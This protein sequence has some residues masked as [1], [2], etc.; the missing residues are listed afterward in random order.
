ML[1]NFCQIIRRSQTNEQNCTLGDP[2]SSNNCMARKVECKGRDVKSM[3]NDDEPSAME[4]DVEHEVVP[5]TSIPSDRLDSLNVTTDCNIQSRVSAMVKCEVTLRRWF[6]HDA[7]S[8]EQSSTP[9]E[10]FGGDSAAAISSECEVQKSELMGHVEQKN[11]AS[12][13]PNSS[14]QSSGDQVKSRRMQRRTK[15]VV[16]SSGDSRDDAITLGEI[17]KQANEVVA[18][19]VL[20]SSD[21]SSGDDTTLGQ[22]SKQTNKR[23]KRSSE[24]AILEVKAR[25]R[26]GRLPK[27]SAKEAASITKTI[28]K[29]TK[30]DKLSSESAILKVTAKSRR[31]RLSKELGEEAASVTNTLQKQAEGKSAFG[32]KARRGRGRPP[33]EYTK[34]ESSVTRTIQKQTKGA[35][36][37]IKDS[38]SIGGNGNSTKPSEPKTGSHDERNSDKVT[39]NDADKEEEG[40]FYKCN[41]PGCGNSFCEAN[42]LKEHIQESH[43][44]MSMFPCPYCSC[45]WS[46]YCRLIEHIPSHIGSMPYRCIQCDVAF[47]TSASLRRH[48]QRSHR[49]NQ[50]FACTTDGCE[51]VTNLWTEFKVH[52]LNYHG[53]EKRHTCFA[54]VASFTNLSDFFAHIESGMATMICCSMC[55]MKSKVPHTILRHIRC[56]H[57]AT[58]GEVLVQTTVK[59][60]QTDEPTAPKT[61]DPI[62]S[63]ETINVCDQCDFADGNQVSFDYH[64]ESHNVLKDLRFAFS[65]QLCPFGSDDRTQYKLHIANHRG[66]PVHQLRSF[67]CT[68]CLFIT[69]QMPIIE[70]HLQEMHT[71]R[72]FN[73]EVQQEFVPANVNDKSTS[74]D[75]ERS[76][77]NHAATQQ[78]EKLEK[79]GESPHAASPCTVPEKDPVRSSVSKTNEGK[80]KRRSRTRRSCNDDDDD[81]TVGIDY[82]PVKK[83]RKNAKKT[84][85]ASAVDTE[86]CTTLRRSSRVSITRTDE[87]E[88]VDC[89][90]SDGADVEQPSIQAGDAVERTSAVIDRFHCD[91]CEFSCNDLQL[92]DDHVSLLHGND[93]QGSAIS[94]SVTSHTEASKS[95]SENSVSGGTTGSEAV[96][97][98]STVEEHLNYRCKLCGVVCHAWVHFKTHMEAMHSYRVI[99]TDEA[100]PIQNIMTIPI[101]TPPAAVENVTEERTTR[102]RAADTSP[103]TSQKNAHSGSQTCNIADM[104]NLDLK[105]VRIRRQGRAVSNTCLYLCCLCS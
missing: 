43:A 37:R 67:K 5:V 71:D 62:P 94:T 1:S 13:G 24:S 25:R 15:R 8:A 95:K 55:K 90:S 76:G 99:K 30:R 105:K 102:T 60:A 63:K 70:K 29:R 20:I 6:P 75:L 27:R 46:D 23:D 97:A 59:C 56:V 3:G 44:S 28:R 74:S 10:I 77:S 41:L 100:F 64:T 101:V 11:V 36:K 69:N 72:P 65:C 54:C 61:N 21:E 53:G 103:K 7:E 73:F 18:S 78:S 31:G 12:V 48:F 50:P 2:I 19:V 45:I 51:F 93:T 14:D 33:R 58:K 85:V 83:K 35:S 68:H 9:K 17:R 81:F 32:A 22:M 47:T 66:T 98:G 91:L 52:N 4:L 92:F 86:G 42:E 40:S 80:A 89:S 88:T 16:S 57:G 96:A 26:R 79:S 87:P 34:D 82:R 38:N 39:T 49:V 84:E 104:T